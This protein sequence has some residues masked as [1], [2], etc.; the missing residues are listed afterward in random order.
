[1]ASEVRYGKRSGLKPRPQ[2]QSRV[3]NDARH[4]EVADAMSMNRL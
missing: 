3:D 2:M 1:M 4:I